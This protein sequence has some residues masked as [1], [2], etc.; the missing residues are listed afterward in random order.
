M[1][2]PL[3]RTHARAVLESV[4]DAITRPLYTLSRLASRIRTRLIIRR[5]RSSD[6][7]TVLAKVFEENVTRHINKPSIL[8]MLL[9]MTCRKRSLRER[10]S[11]GWFSLCQNLRHWLFPEPADELVWDVARWCGGNAETVSREVSEQLPEFSDAERESL[12]REALAAYE[13]RYGAAA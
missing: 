8:P 1:K 10:I 3:T 12:I 4:F 9:G 11:L 6:L 7:A 13:H 2:R 5:H